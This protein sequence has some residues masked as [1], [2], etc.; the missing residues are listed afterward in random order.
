MQGHVQNTAESSSAAAVTQ[1]PSEWHRD[2]AALDW[3]DELLDQKYRR[4]LSPNDLT[5]HTR[6]RELVDLWRSQM[7]SIPKFDQ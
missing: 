1:Y 7:G 6:A 4:G 3:L 2:E 5:Q